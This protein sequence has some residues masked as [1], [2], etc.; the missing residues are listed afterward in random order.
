MVINPQEILMNPHE[1]PD[2]PYLQGGAPQLSWF[3]SSSTDWGY[4]RYVYSY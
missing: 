4:G 1:M 3:I 2:P